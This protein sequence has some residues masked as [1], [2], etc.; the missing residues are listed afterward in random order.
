MDLNKAGSCKLEN[1]TYL[2]ASD[3]FVTLVKNGKC[4]ADYNKKQLSLPLIKAQLEQILD[5]LGVKA[6][7][8]TN[9]TEELTTPLF[10]RR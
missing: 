9:H 6:T 10:Q 4:V 5:H 3:I 2:T 7:I 8:I 1:M